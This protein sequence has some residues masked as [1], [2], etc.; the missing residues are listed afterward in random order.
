LASLLLASGCDGAAQFLPPRANLA[1]GIFYPQ[2]VFIAARRA[3]I[4]RLARVGIE[5]ALAAVIVATA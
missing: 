1:H 3:I 4:K 5:I 2:S